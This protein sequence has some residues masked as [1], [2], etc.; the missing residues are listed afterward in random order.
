MAFLSLAL[1]GGSHAISLEMGNFFFDSQGSLVTTGG[2]VVQGWVRN[3][4]DTG[5]KGSDTDALKVD[6]TGPLENIRI[7]P[8]MVMPARASNRISMRRI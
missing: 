5:N 7:D 1:I 3:G 4:S 6:N 8:G 2:L